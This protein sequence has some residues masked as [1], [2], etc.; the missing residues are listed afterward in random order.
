M[1]MTSIQILWLVL[2][3]SWTLLE[4]VVAVKTR[5]PCLGSEQ[6]YRSEKLIWLV[7]IVA[8]L[9]ALGLKQLQLMK[10][11]IPY[12]PRQ[13]LALLVFSLGLGLRFHAV[14]S[15]GRFFSTTAVTQDQH[16]LIEQGAYRWIRHPA[17]SGLLISFFAAGLA[18]GDILAMLFLLS[19]IIY[20]LTQRIRVEEQSLIEHFG[21]LYYDYC[22]RTKKLIPWVY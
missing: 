10:L 14:F 8:V 15:L 22:Q 19:P 2:G 1:P 7:V 16:I 20:V 13:W 9:A 18:M 11:P 4:I 12:L 6:K 5:E 21:Q 3:G 17:Y